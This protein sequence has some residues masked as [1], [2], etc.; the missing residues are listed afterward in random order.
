MTNGTGMF[1]HVKTTFGE[2][3]SPSSMVN[4]GLSAPVDRAFTA[5]V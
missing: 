3:P 5:P 4:K 2:G 1:K